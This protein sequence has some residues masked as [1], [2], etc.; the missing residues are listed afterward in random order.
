MNNDS[1]FANGW[2]WSAHGQIKAFP[3]EYQQ[4]P[5]VSCI[6]AYDSSNAQFEHACVVNNTNKNTNI[7][8]QCFKAASYAGTNVYISGYI[9][10]IGI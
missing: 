6:G 1:D 10:L 5:F 9:I 7:F 2:R 4:T 8:Y 3:I